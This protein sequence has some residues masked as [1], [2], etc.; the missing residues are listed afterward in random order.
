[1]SSTHN[2]DSQYNCQKSTHFNSESESHWCMTADE[3]SSA[4]VWYSFVQTECCHWAEQ[5][6]SLSEKSE[7]TKQ[8][9]VD[10][11]WEQNWHQCSH[12]WEWWCKHYTRQELYKLSAL[13]HILVWHLHD[14]SC[15]CCCCWMCY[16]RV[17]AE[18]CQ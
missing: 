1:M 2:T 7:H 17:S 15:W 3:F 12:K 14:D 18:R 4:A 13:R 6:W 10:Q 5:E 9:A 8:A 16:M 11:P